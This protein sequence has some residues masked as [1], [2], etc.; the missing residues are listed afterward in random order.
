MSETREKNWKLCWPLTVND[1]S[2]EEPAL[3]PLEVPKF[4]FW[5][6]RKCEREIF[7]EGNDQIDCCNN[8]RRDDCN[9]TNSV[10]NSQIRRPEID[11]NIAIDLFSDG[12]RMVIRDEIDNNAEVANRIAGN[13]FKTSS[14]L[15]ICFVTMI[16]V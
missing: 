7:G 5:S 14:N 8:G 4:R 13:N 15:F 11:L 6:C 9:P 2:E 16:L 3:P 12:D 10:D 1:Q